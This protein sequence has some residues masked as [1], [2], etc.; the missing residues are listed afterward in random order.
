[1][2]AEPQDSEPRGVPHVEGLSVKVTAVSPN[3]KWDWSVTLNGE[4]VSNG[5]GRANNFGNAIRDARKAARRAG[6]SSKD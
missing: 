6:Q 4:E 3:R 5:A 2:T 1:M